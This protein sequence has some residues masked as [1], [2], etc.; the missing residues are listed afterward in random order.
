MERPTCVTCPFWDQSD[1]IN[2][3]VNKVGECR[4]YPRAWNKPTSRM[5][6]DEWPRV[7]EYDWC[8]EHPSFPDYLK[9]LKGWQCTFS[10][11]TI[12]GGS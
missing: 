3:G 7:A 10:R 9:S 5:V 1:L 4:R 12:T 6:S 2:D 11:N 8:G